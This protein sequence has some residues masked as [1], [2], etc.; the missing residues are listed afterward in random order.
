MPANWSNLSAQSDLNYIE[1]FAPIG[2]RFQSRQQLIFHDQVSVA[3][4]KGLGSETDKRYKFYGCR[5]NEL[6]G[7]IVMAYN[8][9]INTHALIQNRCIALW[10]TGGDKFDIN[11]YLSHL[12]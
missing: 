10:H 12:R 8:H 2:L 1:R 11:W 6:S 9:L 3:A 5:Y 7:R 4:E